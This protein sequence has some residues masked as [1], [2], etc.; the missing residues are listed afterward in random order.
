MKH[1][2]IIIGGRYDVVDEQ[3]TRHTIVIVHDYGNGVLEVLID[4]EEHAMAKPQL[5]EW[6]TNSITSNIYSIHTGKTKSL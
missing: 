2:E 5:E 3:G 4:G 1:I 6:L